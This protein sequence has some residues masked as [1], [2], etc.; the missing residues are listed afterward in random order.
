LA[1]Y[2]HINGIPCTDFHVTLPRQGVWVA[3]AELAEDVQLRGAVTASLGYGAMYLAGTAR[4][5][6]TYEGRARL[7]V[8]AGGGGLQL[9]V[10]PKHYRAVTT[11]QLLSD[12]VGQCGE[13]LALTCDGDELE[14]GHT[15]WV[16]LGGTLADQ[17]QA[18][19][20]LRPGYAWRMLAGGQ[21]WMGRD[22]FPQSSAA[23][24]ILNASPEENRA[25]FDF[26]APSLLP[27]QTYR[28]QPVSVVEYH[29]QGDAKS[30]TV[31][32]EDS[33]SAPGEVS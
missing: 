4:Y 22:T 20:D 26:D 15:N 24:L 28:D 13:T 25:T 1:D 23:S 10:T 7:T 11:Q 18:Y 17:L 32:W 6:G 30:A 31:W 3:T 12:W 21:L 14:R 33:P 9:P 16:V 29:V 8:V 2:V 19:L 27:G 5:A